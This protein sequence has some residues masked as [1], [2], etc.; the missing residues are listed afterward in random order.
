MRRRWSVT[1]ATAGFYALGSAPAWAGATAAPTDPDGLGGLFAIPNLAGGAGQTLFEATATEDYRIYS[2]LGLSDI[3]EKTAAVIYE[4]ALALAMALVKLAIGLTWWL[5]ALTSRDT[6]VAEL[7]TNLQAVAADLNTW[8]LPTA[9]GVGVVVAYGIARAGRD[10]FSQVLWTLGLGVGA[11][12]MAVSGPA[13]LSGVDQARQLLAR[14]VTGIGT[15]SVSDQGMPF[16]WPGA[17]LS[18]GDP[19]RDLARG[20]GDAVWRSFAAVPWCQVQFGSQAACRAYGPTWLTLTT[21][22]ERKEYVESTITEA[23]GGSS[24][25]PTVRYV[26]GYDP[27]SRIA[28]ALFSVVT[29]IAAVVVIGGL[30]L[31]ALM[32]WVTALLLMSLMTV[33][34]CLLAVPGRLR[35]IGLDFLNLIGGLILLSALTTAILSG[36]ELAIVAATSLAATQGWLPVAIMLTA[37]MFAAWHARSILERVLFVSEA[38]GGRMGAIGLALGIT[39]MRRLLRGTRSAF[40]TR[41]GGSAATSQSV[42]GGGRGGRGG[43]AGGGG[44]PAGSGGGSGGGGGAPVRRRQAFYPKRSAAPSSGQPVR[45]SLNGTAPA[46]RGALAPSGAQQNGTRELRPASAPAGSSGTRSGALVRPGNASPREQIRWER[47][48][49]TQRRQAPSAHAIRYTLPPPVQSAPRP[50]TLPRRVAPREITRT[51][52]HVRRVDGSRARSTRQPG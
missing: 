35:R 2:D 52:P 29:S 36:A 39:A 13:I 1:A 23:E 31:L 49:S 5:N 8:L 12:A 9:L 34:L 32:P 27:A 43:S 40:R 38:G 26:R 25:A 46:G 18:T 21:D 45:P 10:A 3:T 30:A 48:R 20:S 42:G 6:G 37:I 11:V 4:G 19:T 44:A 41:S 7:G 51:A 17:S 24:D 28:V 16:E 15:A 50:G 22:D 14:T 47:G 33:F